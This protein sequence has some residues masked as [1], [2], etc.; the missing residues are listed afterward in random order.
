MYQI[1]PIVEEFSSRIQYF[2]VNLSPKKLSKEHSNFLIH[3]CRESE[4]IIIRE[5]LAFADITDMKLLTT[6]PVLARA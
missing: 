6:N 5:L 1:A 2:L 3:L 4:F